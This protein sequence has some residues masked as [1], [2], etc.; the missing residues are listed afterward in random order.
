MSP[1]FQVQGGVM[2]LGRKVIREKREEKTFREVRDE[3]EE[4]DKREDMYFASA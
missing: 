2:I 1:H 4:K 3:W